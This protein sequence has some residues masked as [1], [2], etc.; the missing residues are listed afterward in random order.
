MTEA[1]DKALF[2]Y[3]TRYYRDTL[4]L[5]DWETLAQ[6]R[7]HEEDDEERRITRLEQ[8]IGSLR[9]KHV[10]SVGCG[11]GGF[12][13]VA[14]RHGATVEGVEPDEPAVTIAKEK[15]KRYGLNPD[16]FIVG[17]AEKLPYDDNSFDLVHCYTVLEHVASVERSIKEMLRVMKPDGRLYVHSPNYLHAYEGHYKILWPPLLPKPLGHVY[18]KARGRPSAFLNT[19]NYLTPTW[20]R[21]ATAR[22]GGQVTDYAEPGA[23]N[24]KVGILAHTVAFIERTLNIRPHIEVVIRKS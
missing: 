7:T 10:L 16:K 5:P 3:Y 13:V 21:R 8:L 4:G 1:L 12:A 2:D 17:V 20:V 9:G 22:A 24:P 6:A 18:L 23:A 11:T 15:A 19:I 14:A